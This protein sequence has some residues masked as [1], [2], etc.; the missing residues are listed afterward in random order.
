MS[1]KGL[2]YVA[3]MHLAV[4]IFQIAW[5]ITLN[6]GLGGCGPTDITCATPLDGFVS[7]VRQE[8][9]ISLGYAISIIGSVL[10]LIWGLLSFNY[11]LFSGSSVVTTGIGYVFRLGFGLMGLELV[12]KA[13][14][15]VFQAVRG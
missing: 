14:S 4:G 13:I 15:Y 10:G 7:A 9:S 1:A 11:A 8:P 12:F 5:G 2:F 3:L 6:T